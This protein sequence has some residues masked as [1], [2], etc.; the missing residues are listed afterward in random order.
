MQ[1]PSEADSWHAA[2]LGVAQRRGSRTESVL[3]R[4]TKLAG[5]VATLAL[6]TT[7]HAEVV[8]YSESV[9]GDLPNFGNPLSTFTFDIG[10]NTIS[11]RTGVSGVVVDGDSFAFIVPV[12]A[13][14]VA[15]QVQ[16][17]DAIGDV[18]AVVWRLGSNS[19][20]YLGGAFVSNVEALSPATT[21]F[22]SSGLG[23]GNYN[24]SAST[25]SFATPNGYFADY[26]FSFTL[27]SINQVPEPSSL[28]LFG[29]AGLAGARAR[30]RGIARRTGH[31]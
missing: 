7:A 31:T 29:I 16:M 11:G 2:C 30:L 13:E 15:A 19:L 24:L 6:A 20:L 27:R 12:G 9:S 18:T 5:A 21:V 14:L 1:R 25:I 28:A 22:A 10:A 8:N 23:A 26:T 4:V 17:T 3:N